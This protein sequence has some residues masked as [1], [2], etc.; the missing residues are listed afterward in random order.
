MVVLAGA[1]GVVA[2]LLPSRRAGKVPVLEA[3]A[4]E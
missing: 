4:Y 3:I 2:A 1:V